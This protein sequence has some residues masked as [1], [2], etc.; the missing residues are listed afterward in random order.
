VFVGTAD[1]DVHAVDGWTG[2][3]EWSADLYVE[4]VHSAWRNARAQTH[5]LAFTGVTALAVD[6]D[7][8]F[9]GTHNAVFALDV[10]RG[11]IH[12]AVDLGCGSVTTLERVDDRLVFGSGNGGVY[13]L[14][15]WDGSGGLVAEFGETVY[16]AVG[17]E[18]LYVATEMGD[19]HGIRFQ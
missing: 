3:V 16:P 4:A 8:L 19:V 14:A 13:S 5:P 9:V 18:T 7:Y 6:D 12:W 1:N 17:G 15:R 2:E 11:G 10:E